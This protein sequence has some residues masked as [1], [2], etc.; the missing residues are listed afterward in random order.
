MLI[1]E[2]RSLLHHQ[3]IKDFLPKDF[4]KKMVKLNGAQLPILKKAAV[5]RREIIHI[6]IIISSS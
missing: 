5:A 6:A 1:R 4:L 3:T 2:F